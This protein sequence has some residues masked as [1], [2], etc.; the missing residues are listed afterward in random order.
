M[1]KT[2][3]EIVYIL[4]FASAIAIA[5]NFTLPKP[6]SLL[7]ENKAVEVVD[8]ALLFS[9][10]TTNHPANDNIKK[11]TLIATNNPTLPTDTN[12]ISKKIDTNKTKIAQNTTEIAHNKENVADA[13]KNLA[14]TVS[15]Q[16]M[17]KIIK[18]NSFIII[19]ARNP[20]N[21][22]RDK[23]GDAINIFPYGEEG[24]MMNQIMNLPSDKKIVVYCDG[25]ACDASHK[26]AEIIVSFGYDKVFIYTGGWEEWI[27]KQKKV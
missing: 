9:E 14:K 7:K 18:D 17:L 13:H 25:G 20:D 27:I 21:F 3:K 19:D 10:D 8:D 12:K 15:Y 16:Q 4:I 24:E 26:L 5:Y 11:D 6:L 1:N 23:I 22:A 2:V